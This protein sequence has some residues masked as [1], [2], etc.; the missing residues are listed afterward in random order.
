MKNQDDLFLSSTNFSEITLNEYLKHFVLNLKD[1]IL[2]SD[3]D[4]DDDNS[5]EEHLSNFIEKIKQ[6]SIDVLSMFHQE[7]QIQKPVIKIIQLCELN[8]F[9][10][11]KN[12]K[13]KIHNGFISS[14]SSIFN[15]F[16]FQK[17]PVDKENWVLNRKLIDVQKKFLLKNDFGSPIDSFL[18]GL[19][20]VLVRR[21]K[22][23]AINF[24][25]QIIEKILALGESRTDIF[26]ES[27]LSG[28]FDKIE[29]HLENT[30][31]IGDD[32]GLYCLLN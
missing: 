23:R 15:S 27:F 9:L 28:R 25:I 20:N 24:A 8:I 19:R 17:F 21:K 14:I 29:H 22:S 1:D 32:G 10:L 18:D 16:I 13:K 31:I 26:E 7:S 30:V 2:D 12:S 4:F 6:E 5:I 3:H 11:E